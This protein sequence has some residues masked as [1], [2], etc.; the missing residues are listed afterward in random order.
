MQNKRSRKFMASK[1]NLKTSMKFIFITRFLDQ[2]NYMK[3]QRERNLR[4]IY[5]IYGDTSYTNALLLDVFGNELRPIKFS[6]TFTKFIFKEANFSLRNEFIDR[7]LKVIYY[8]I[9][10]YS[11]RSNDNRV[12]GVEGLLLD[13]FCSRNNLSYIVT[14]EKYAPF[15]VQQIFDVCLYRRFTCNNCLIMDSKYINDLGASQ[16]LLVPR[17][18]P[19]YSHILSSP[20]DNYVL[21]TF[22][23][24]FLIIGILWKIIRIFRKQNL[25][26]FR[27]ILMLLKIIFGYSID[28]SDFNRWSI[29]ERLLLFPFLVICFI[30]MDIFKSFIISTS[31]V[32]QPMRSVQSIEELISSDTMIYEY[33]KEVPIFPH[34]KVLNH[35]PMLFG[36]SALSKLPENVDENL[37]YAVRCRFA[38]EFVVSDKNF[39]KNRQLF[40]ILD[41]YVDKTY[42][43]Y[44]IHENYP[45]KNELKFLVAYLQESGI[46]DHWTKST[47][48]ETFPK[49]HIHN[50][51]EN[52]I[53]LEALYLPLSILCIGIFMCV[54][55]FLLELL[56]NKYR[57]WKLSRVI[58]LRKERK[59]REKFKK[60]HKILRVF[61]FSKTHEKE[62]RRQRTYYETKESD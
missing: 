52:V 24:S 28:D 44:L 31:I 1:F 12:V 20:Y 4:Q 19:T 58:D 9:P 11:Y 55:I 48:I 50:D 61:K 39:D 3:Y 32:D 23:I 33:Y 51:S 57:N 10:P 45:L 35:V 14:N 30:L 13:E 38:E 17:N 34:H 2:G 36:A 16:C 54:V 26:N 27:L 37:A 41:G 43:T 59:K 62:L 21:I 46:L 7:N 60:F 15:N 56:F 40:D 5:S 8:D 47:I 18:I 29:K 6:A 25:N 22:G 53:V 49:Q 42:S